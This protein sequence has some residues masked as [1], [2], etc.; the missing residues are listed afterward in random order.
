MAYYHSRFGDQ[1]LS[2]YRS[3]FLYK[4]ASRGLFKGC[5]RGT[6]NK[7]YILGREEFR[8]DSS[9]FLPLGDTGNNIYPF[10][11]RM[12]ILVAFKND[13]VKNLY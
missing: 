1:Y 4:L 11:L 10:I 6:C 7:E 5:G 3:I 2:E 12:V 13:N 8:D 9:K